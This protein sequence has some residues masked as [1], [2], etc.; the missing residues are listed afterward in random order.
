VTIPQCVHPEQR[1]L[2]DDEMVQ[3]ILPGQSRL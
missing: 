1:S 3:E 2:T